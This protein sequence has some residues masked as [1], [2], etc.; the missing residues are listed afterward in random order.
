MLNNVKIMKFWVKILKR[1]EKLKGQCGN[2]NIYFVY[3]T[4]M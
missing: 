2:L 4:N 1:S 3:F